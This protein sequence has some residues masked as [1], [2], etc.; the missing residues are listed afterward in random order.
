MSINRWVDKQIVVYAN[1]AIL[2]SSKKEWK[3]W[4]TQQDGY[5]SKYA[6]WCNIDKRNTYRRIPLIYNS[7]NAN[8]SNVIENR[9]VVAWLRGQEDWERKLPSDIRVL[10][11]VRDIFIILIVVIIS[12]MCTCAKTCQIVHFTCMHLII[13]QWCFSWPIKILWQKLQDVSDLS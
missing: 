7:E 2:L 6:E 12:R 1:N 10:L 5:I 11:G 4:Y 9:S 3:Y 8:E 13:C